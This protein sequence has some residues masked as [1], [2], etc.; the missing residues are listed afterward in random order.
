M[1]KKAFKV[2]WVIIIS[3]I[4]V[5]TPSFAATGRVTGTNVRI[6]ERADSKAPEISVATKNE[7]VE[8]IGEEGNWYKVNF[9]TITGY[10]SKDYVDTDYTSSS[11]SQTETPAPTITT[12][13]PTPE[14]TPA[15]ATNTAEPEP[16]TNTTTQPVNN[17]VANTVENNVTN[18]TN[19]VAQNTVTDSA[20]EVE[21]DQKVKFSSEADLKYL[22]SF[23]SRTSSKVTSGEVYTVKENLNNWIKV[24]NGNNSGWVLKAKVIATDEDV[25]TTPETQ[26][27]PQE[28][29]P[30]QEQP[31]ATPTP[32][33][34]KGTVIVPSARIRKSPNGEQLDSLEEGTEVTI[35]GE[36]NDWYKISVNEYDSCYIAK[37]LIK[38]K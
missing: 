19:E 35:L 36:E 34:K 16:D 38:E 12:P 11:S 14:P 6:R 9:E 15:P 33:T 17:A 2:F 32:E 4:L 18:S 5:V 31:P 27:P 26:T 20:N 28:T 1:V 8:V 22:P 10:I 7:T 13:E 21:K 29:T 25:T 30:T 24:E 37:R 3:F 23:T